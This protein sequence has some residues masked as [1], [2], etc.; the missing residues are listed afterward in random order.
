[1]ASLDRLSS[2][3]DLEITAAK[4]KGPAYEM[5]SPANNMMPGRDMSQKRSAHKMQFPANNIMSGRDGR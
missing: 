2:S 4:K 1:M 5:Q 3:K